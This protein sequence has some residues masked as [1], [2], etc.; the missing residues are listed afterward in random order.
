MNQFEPILLA[1]TLTLAGAS[2]AAYAAHAAPGL[3][4][5]TF[6]AAQQ[7]AGGTLVRPDMQYSSARGF[8]FEPGAAVRIAADNG[9]P[10]YL[11][12]DRPFFFSADLPEGNYN[13]TVTL[14]GAQAATTTVKAEL[15]RLMLE[16]VATAPGATVTRSFTVNIRTPRIPA[17]GGIAAGRVQLKEPRETVQEAWAWDKRLTLEFNGER[18]A[19]RAIDITPVQAPTIF[20]LGDSTVCDQPGEPYNSWGQMLPR[21]LKPGVAVANHGE[22]G[23]TYRDSLARRRLDKILSAMR[24]GDTV[25]M[26]FGHN[27][28]KQIKD[29]KGGPFTTYKDEIRA[30]VEAIRAHG[31]TPVIISPMERRRFDDSG[32]IVPSLADYA[33]AARQS[34]QELQAAF[35]DLN[36]MS[37][38]FYE[39]LGPELSQHAF[40]EREPGRIDNTHHSNYGSYELAQAVLTGMRKAGVPAAALIADGYGNFEPSRPDP[41]AAFAVPPSP[42]FSNDT[43]LGDDNVGQRGQP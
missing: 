25:L 42:Q 7:A 26:Q 35:I 23:E 3:W 18:P 4:R 16:Q 38:P 24:P 34:A 33:E 27:D 31:G 15:R 12:S 32:K 13:V 5:F 21:F 17:V 43:P 30:H 37:K 2:S 6:D 39:A 41:V 11:T 14:G 28:Q 29:G 9:R 20:V 40:A 10:A 19:I 22:S 1:L 36:A 8:G